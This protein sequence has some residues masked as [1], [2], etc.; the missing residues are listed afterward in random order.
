MLTSNRQARLADFL[1]NRPDETKD[2][3]RVVNFFN[4]LFN[5][6]Y[7]FMIGAP[8]HV[9]VGWLLYAIGQ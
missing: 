9:V 3:G 2:K 6:V 5:A 7:Q 1:D 8:Q 4:G